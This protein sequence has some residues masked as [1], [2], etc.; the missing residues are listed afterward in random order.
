MLQEICGFK[1]KSSG[2]WKICNKKKTAVERFQNATASTHVGKSDKV[3]AVNLAKK[4]HHNVSRN[5]LSVK[6]EAFSGG[7]CIAS[8]CLNLRYS[9]LQQKQ[10]CSAATTSTAYSFLS[11]HKIF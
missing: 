11:D 8:K 7:F 4:E 2:T 1:R 5:A 9:V 6:Y 3:L 10:S